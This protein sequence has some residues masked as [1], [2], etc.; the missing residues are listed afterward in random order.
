MASYL[1]M[2]LW[3][4]KKR[5]KEMKEKMETKQ[6]KDAVM[7]FEEI[8][9]LWNDVDQALGF[10]QSAAKG[11]Q[12]IV[13]A[14]VGR[15]STQVLVR[16]DAWISRMSRSLPGVEKRKL[17]VVDFNEKKVFTSSSLE[18]AKSQVKDD[19]ASKV[20]DKILGANIEVKSKGE[21]KPPSGESGRRDKGGQDDR[22]SSSSWSNRN[23]GRSNNFRGFNRR[24]GGFGQD[25][26]N[27][28][29]NQNW[30]Q[31]SGRGGQAQNFNQRRG[32]GGGRGASN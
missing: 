1:D 2:F 10:L 27:S 5:L 13:Q 23:K 22:Y 21:N 28:N 29:W 8:Q 32:S 9:D 19:K 26:G 7:V 24:R 25:R 18:H 4:G 6:T 3:A 31:N 12:D 15:V 14:T 11:L 30:H 17:R 20:Q 16:R